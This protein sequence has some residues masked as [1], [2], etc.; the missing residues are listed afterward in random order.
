M[1]DIK[2]LIEN[3]IEG[4]TVFNN[5]SALNPEHIPANLP[6]RE[7]QIKE[8]T[9]SFKDLIINPGS[10]SIRTVIVG[11]TGT[12]K[13]VTAKKFG[14]ELKGIANQKGLKL[15]YVHVNCHRQ[16]TL[17]L[18]LMEIAQ[19]LRLPLPNRGLSSQ[20]TFK[21]IYDYLERKNLHLL[22]TLDEFDYFISTSPIEDI[23]FL[24]RIY[25]ELNV[26]VKRLHY[27][28]IVRELSTLS[29]LDKSIKDHIIKNIIEFS[30][31][32]SSDLYDILQDR[33]INEKAF[34]PNAVSDE[35]IKFISD[36]HGAD[37]GGSG[38]ARLAIETLELAGKIADTEN[39]PIITVEHAKKANSKINPE[40]SVITDTI[41]DLDLH[42][43]LLL[44]AI[45]SLHKKQG[46]DFFPMGRVEEE[47]RTVASLLGEEPRRHTQIFEY[48]RRL[49]LMGLILTR[50]SSKGMRGRTTLISLPI[51]V[52]TELEELLDGEIKRRLQK[53]RL[54][55]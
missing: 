16:R 22:L 3:T 47:Y 10:T 46:E 4:S 20:E 42:Y 38:N 43:L 21:L 54:S 48:I 52:S 31:Y 41:K 2:D 37:K 19:N 12:G 50:H 33:I 25:D 45:S 24:V 26:S 29:G 27:I 14:N 49:K 53:S 35:A 11:R 44:K 55:S 6:H 18:M 13:T 34:K 17:Y 9:V 36:I 28:F 23:Y 8:L 51:P 5:T 30:P 39:A 15:Y 40:M 7:N 1:V 32:T